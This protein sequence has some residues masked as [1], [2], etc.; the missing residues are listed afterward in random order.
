M[1]KTTGFISRERFYDALA[2]AAGGALLLGLSQGFNKVAPVKGAPDISDLVQVDRITDSHGRT[3][4]I[5]IMSRENYETW[6]DTR[7]LPEYQSYFQRQEDRLS[8]ELLPELVARGQRHR[9]ALQ[10]G[11]C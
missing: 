11:L 2:L 3:V 1:K 9:P 4:Y 7:P 5:P 6:R 10:H 8:D